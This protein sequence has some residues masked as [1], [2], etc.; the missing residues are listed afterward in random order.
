MSAPTVSRMPAYLPTC[1]PAPSP[2]LGPRYVPSPCSAAFSA[3]LPLPPCLPQWMPF[4]F[5]VLPC[6]NYS[7][8]RIFRVSSPVPR[9]LI[10]L[11]LH[12]HATPHI[13]P[14]LILH[15]FHA[16]IFT[17]TVSY[18]QQSIFLIFRLVQ[19]RGD[20][21]RA[22]C[23]QP[24]QRDHVERAR[25]WQWEDTTCISVIHRQRESVRNGGGYKAG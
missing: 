3:E 25:S 5:S 16:L 12:L 14:Y 21:G 8:V 18:V 13:F 6:M 22:R 7:T 23:Q 9:N 20:G 2:Y 19:R 11:V 10:C 17:R 24:G 15:T 1:L 4:F